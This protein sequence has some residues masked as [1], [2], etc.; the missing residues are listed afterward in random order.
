M[1]YDLAIIGG[2]PGGVAAGVYA[3]RKNLKT[4]IIAHEIG[5]QSTVSPGVQNWVGT[6]RRNKR[7]G[8]RYESGKSRTPRYNSG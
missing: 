1:T 3:S 2:G 8:M 7:R 5:G 6:I 4:I